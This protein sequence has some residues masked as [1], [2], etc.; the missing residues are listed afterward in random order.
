MSFKNKYF[1]KPFCITTMVITFKD[2]DHATLT[3]ELLFI[4]QKPRYLFTLLSKKSSKIKKLRHIEFLGNFRE[5]D[6]RSVY[7][8]KNQTG[9]F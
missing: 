7:F 5:D 9:K 8:K 6:K 3:P 2:G 4:E 1:T